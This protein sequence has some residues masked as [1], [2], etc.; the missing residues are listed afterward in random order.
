[1]PPE[2]N[3]EPNTEPTP[4]PNPEPTATENAIS[5][6]KRRAEDAEKKARELEKKVSEQEAAISALVDGSKKQNS[7]S[8]AFYAG[9]R[10]I[11]QKED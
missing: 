6:L 7:A 11:K 9:L 10:Y 1:M 8:A 5:E 3:T 2:P 4:A